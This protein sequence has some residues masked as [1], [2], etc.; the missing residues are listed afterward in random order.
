MIDVSQGKITRTIAIGAVATALTS[1]A[2]AATN[3]VITEVTVFPGVAQVT[4]QASLLAG[5]HALTFD[6]LP[7]GIRQQALSV[8]AGA[9]V[10][11]GEIS[12]ERIDAKQ[13][14][15][16]L[17]SPLDA[18]IER[19]EDELAMLESE[20]QG[21]DLSVAYLR[22][23]SG[24]KDQAAVAPTAPLPAMLGT[25][26]TEAREA[27]KR[28]HSIE[29]EKQR[30][31]E[32]LV[33]LAA[34]R[35]RLGNSRR[36]IS[37]VTIRTVASKASNLA[38]V[39]QV[40]GPTW[41]PAYRAYLDSASASIKLE[42]QAMVRQSTGE[43][44]MGVALRLSTGQPRRGAS[45]P[46]P[47]P[48]TIGIAIPQKPQDDML[49]RRQNESQFAD[50]AMAAVPDMP[51]PIAAPMEREFEVEAIDTAFRTEFVAPQKLDVPSN[52]QKVGLTLE[53]RKLSS[54]L[55][56]RTVP[57]R[58]E[59]AW[60]MAEMKAPEGIWPAGQVQ[61]YRD[62]AFVG[63]ASLGAPD[64]KGLWE[65]PFGQDERVS[66]T[67]LPEE[68]KDG[69]RGLTGSR[70][71]KSIRRVFEVENRHKDAIELQVLEASPSSRHEDVAVST[72]FKPSPQTQKWRDLPGVVEWRAPLA[73]GKEMRFEAS[74]VYSWPEDATLTP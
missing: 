48:W 2:H 18:D 40:N 47:S 19:L 55:F 14:P 64:K 58:D 6:C 13:A 66:V 68:V 46:V 53:S 22:G 50:L 72:E 26:R 54:K 57:T 3:S 31:T 24:G 44:W 33:P 23:L 20:R 51:S 65:L 42:R 63:A 69:T 59:S 28:M 27:F 62:Q 10:Q 41:Q 1:L 35:N 36:Q 32:K 52:G 12:V 15:H 61:L 34:E 60:L 39:Y 56:V 38:L 9:G 4:R 21:L 29:R 45:A 73:A 67:A 8:E 7:A 37:R 74:Y 17:I 5:S 43:D 30:I 25:V 49:K 16:C 71:E 70:L 11:V